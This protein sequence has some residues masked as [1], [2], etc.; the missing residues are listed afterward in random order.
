MSLITDRCHTL[1]D[2]TKDL[3]VKNVVVHAHTDTVLKIA[4]NLIEK[5][6]KATRVAHDSENMQVPF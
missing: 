4:K 5:G 2:L 6:Y 1:T 3:H